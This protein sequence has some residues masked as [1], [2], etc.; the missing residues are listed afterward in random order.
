MSERP[1][2]GRSRMPPPGNDNERPVRTLRTELRIP[3][4]LPI[5]QVEVEVFAELLDAL[6]EVVAN[7]NEEPGQ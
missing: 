6:E 4:G 5:Q 1:S 7:D 2:T 3:R